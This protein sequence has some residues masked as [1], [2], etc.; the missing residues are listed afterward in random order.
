MPIKFSQSFFLK[1]DFLIFGLPANWSR[2]ELN[3]RRYVNLNQLCRRRRVGVGVWIGPGWQNLARVDVFT[4]KHGIFLFYI[5]SKTKAWYFWVICSICFGRPRLDNASAGA[6]AK[7]ISQ[8]NVPAGSVAIIY[9]RG[10]GQ[11]FQTGPKNFTRGMGPAAPATMAAGVMTL[12]KWWR[13]IQKKTWILSLIPATKVLDLER[14]SLLELKW[15]RFSF[16]IYNP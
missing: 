13:T 11:K 2:I 8:G 5:N 4:W 14:F 6:G 9:S 16:K 15:I 10:Q 12:L 3:P 7:E 1:I